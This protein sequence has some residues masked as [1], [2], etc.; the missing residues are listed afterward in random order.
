MVAAAFAP[1]KL[2]CVLFNCLFRFI[3]HSQRLVFNKLY[4]SRKQMYAFF[5]TVFVF[6]EKSTTTTQEYLSSLLKIFVFQP[7]PL[8]FFGS[9]SGGCSS[10]EGLIS[11]TA[12]CSSLRTLFKSFCSCCFSCCHSCC[13][14]FFILFHG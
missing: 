5:W 12:S 6:G 10:I 4:A 13:F 3:P 2:V 9:G 11:H 1:E 14:S 8:P 7:F